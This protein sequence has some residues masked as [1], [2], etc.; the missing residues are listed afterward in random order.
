MPRSTRRPQ[1]GPCLRGAAARG[2]AVAACGPLALL[3]LAACGQASTE[4]GQDPS[5]GEGD[6]PQPTAQQR[7]PENLQDDPRNETVPVEPPLPL[8]T[9][10]PGPLAPPEPAVKRS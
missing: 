2:V 9:N 10:P 4:T 8:P 7:V 3:L 6:A 1:G 5:S